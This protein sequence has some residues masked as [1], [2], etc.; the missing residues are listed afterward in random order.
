M[1]KQLCSF[2]K[3]QL[4][5]VKCINLLNK[6]LK[7]AQLR[8]AFI[9]DGLHLF[10]T[11]SH[12]YQAQDTHSDMF[13]TDFARLINVAIKQV[14]ALEGNKE[15]RQNFDDFLDALNGKGIYE[16]TINSS[17][18]ATF[19]KALNDPAGYLHFIPKN[20]KVDKL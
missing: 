2:D 4:D 1:T 13:I 17:E 9:Y 8:A 11:D 18:Y 14:P 10:P 7:K 16:E 15:F 6:S 20:C 5:E 12:P 19:K 3:T